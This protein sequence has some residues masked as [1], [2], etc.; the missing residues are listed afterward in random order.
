MTTGFNIATDITRDS[1]FVSMIGFTEEE[2]KKLIKGV[3][4]NGTEDERKNI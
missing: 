3:F 2:T 4:P 1:E